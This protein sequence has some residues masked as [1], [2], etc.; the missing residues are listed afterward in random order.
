MQKLSCLEGSF[1][2][3][4]YEKQQHVYFIC[5]NIQLC[6]IHVEPHLVNRI[7]STASSHSKCWLRLSA[8]QEVTLIPSFND[9]LSR[10][11]D[12]S[13]NAGR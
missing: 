7:G 1:L 9:E 2:F 5:L 8:C 6:F 4:I 10:N 3:E 12:E 11:T 13:P